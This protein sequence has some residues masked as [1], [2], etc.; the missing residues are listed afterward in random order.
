MRGVCCSDQDDIVCIANKE[1]LSPPESPL[2]QQPNPPVPVA[3]VP[4]PP[5]KERV[6]SK[7]PK[8]PRPRMNTSQFESIIFSSELSVES[9]SQGPVS[10]ALLSHRRT[11]NMREEQ[12]I[13]P[14]RPKISSSSNEPSERNKPNTSGAMDEERKTSS[15]ASDF[16]ESFVKKVSSIVVA[17]NHERLSRPKSKL[18][19]T[20]T[21]LPT[22]GSNL[23]HSPSHDTTSESDNSF[24]ALMSSSELMPFQD[25]HMRVPKTNPEIIKVLAILNN[26]KKSSERFFQSQ[27]SGMLSPDD[28]VGIIECVKNGDNW[29]SLLTKK[30]ERKDNWLFDVWLAGCVDLSINDLIP[31][32]EHQSHAKKMS[33]LLN[34]DPTPD[35]H[36]YRLFFGMLAKDRPIKLRHPLTN[37]E[38]DVFLSILID[39]DKTIQSIQSKGANDFSWYFN[40]RIEKTMEQTPSQKPSEQSSMSNKNGFFKPVPP[41]RMVTFPSQLYPPLPGMDAFS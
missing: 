38:I 10:N 21:L 31:L 1:P 20:A 27:Q 33:N 11:N 9:I 25:E 4:T 34:G 19:D 16:D 5:K 22:S 28:C 15:C 35:G 41:S 36:W 8:R 23:P 12:E 7:L 2:S 24:S 14:V 13:N 32:R 3:L 37:D 40:V 26:A 6:N 30:P 17:Q 18:F 39:F 29:L